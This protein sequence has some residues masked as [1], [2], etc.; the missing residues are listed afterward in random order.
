MG[1]ECTRVKV[2]LAYTGAKERS[3]E[4]FC[5]PSGHSMA[6]WALAQ[7]GAS[8]EHRTESSGAWNSSLRSV[9]EELLFS[10]NFAEP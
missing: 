6:A 5:L 2:K 4:F 9:K 8:G 7:A 3:E 1:D 10:R